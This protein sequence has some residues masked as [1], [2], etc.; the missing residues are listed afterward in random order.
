MAG[1]ARTLVSGAVGVMVVC[2]LCGL[3]VFC[4][5]GALRRAAISPK[6]RICLHCVMECRLP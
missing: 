5:K 1:P 4:W 2:A 3:G 6:C